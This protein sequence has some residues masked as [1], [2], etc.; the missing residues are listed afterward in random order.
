MQIGVT[1]IGNVSPI[2][3]VGRLIKSYLRSRILVSGGT[4]IHSVNSVNLAP[5]ALLLGFGVM[6]V[7]S[8]DFH[9]LIT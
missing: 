2:L 5:V 9:C 1:R 6:G 3:N 4:W 7:F 8:S